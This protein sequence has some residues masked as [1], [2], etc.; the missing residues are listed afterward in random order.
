MSPKFEDIVDYV[1]S[2]ET[3][4]GIARSVG[5]YYWDEHGNVIKTQIGSKVGDLYDE[6]TI[7]DLVFLTMQYVYLV[8]PEK[9]A[10]HE[11]V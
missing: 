10:C 9:E 6:E 4:K 7:Q 2:C 5:Q 3:T 8:M 11:E 1:K